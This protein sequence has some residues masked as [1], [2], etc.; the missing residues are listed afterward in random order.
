M[1][2]VFGNIEHVI[3][4]D[5]ES[6]SGFR[7]THH[8]PLNVWRHRQNKEYETVTIPYSCENKNKEANDITAVRRGSRGLS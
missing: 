1:S 3:L 4:A 6:T 7:R 2:Y 8:G 5:W